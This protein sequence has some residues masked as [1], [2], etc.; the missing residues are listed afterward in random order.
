MMLIKEHL[1]TREKYRGQNTHNSTNIYSFHKYLLGS[2]FVARAIQRL[3]A[4]AVHNVS[5]KC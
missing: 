4:L 1:G 3:E 2:R 5:V